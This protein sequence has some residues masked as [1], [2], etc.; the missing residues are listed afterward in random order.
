MNWRGWVAAAVAGAW[1]VAIALLALQAWFM[2]RI[3]WPA[4]VGLALALAVVFGAARWGRAVSAGGVAA[5]RLLFAAALVHL[6][7]LVLA[8]A[9]LAA[10]R[11]DNLLLALL[12]WLMLEAASPSRLRGLR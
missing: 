6:L 5:R 12:G 7:P 1:A 9:G 8:L 3:A 11:V 4:L 10:P 2:A